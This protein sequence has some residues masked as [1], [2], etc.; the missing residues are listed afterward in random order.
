MIPTP[1][2]DIEIADAHLHFFSREFYRIQA[3]QKGVKEVGTLLGWDVP[4][5][6]EELADRWIAEMDRHGV[7]TAVLV[8]SVSGD[9]ESVETAVDR[10]PRRFR[11]VVMMNPLPPGA[12]MR[13]S[14]ALEDGFVK[15]IFLFPA[16][17]KY[18]MHDTR[19]HS[20][21]SIA[22]G[23]P[24]T[25]VYVHFGMLSV[26]FR[27]KLGLHSP[28]DMRFS[29]PVDLHGVALAFPQ[30]NF[31]IPHFGAGY[32]REALMVADLCP[33]VYLDTSSSNKWMRC[34]PGVTDL[35]GVFRRALDVIGPKR[36][37]FGTDS[38]WF[39]RGWVRGVFD[40][41]VLAMQAA[42]VDAET[43]RGILGGNLRALFGE[44]GST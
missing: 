19:V 11:S 28:F 20:L 13:C 14:R 15:G 44:Q 24:G 34:E 26:G 23:F 2:G 17:H 22:A 10:H 35:A 43:A 42:A 41:Q 18:S 37:L 32:L 12:D 21:L 29:N 25:A 3:E 9:I 6:S 36:L 38:S 30:V 16:M 5:S 27:K 1:W 4:N 40:E 33:N 7:E 39:P 31:V 8:A